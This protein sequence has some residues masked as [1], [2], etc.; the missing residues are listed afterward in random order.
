[1][2]KSIL[3]VCL[4]MSM[5]LVGIPTSAQEPY[6]PEAELG[7]VRLIGTPEFVV[8]LLP[9]GALHY[10]AIRRNSSGFLVGVTPPGWRNDTL[11]PRLVDR[12][13]RATLTAELYNQGGGMYQ[14][15]LYFEGSVVEQGEFAGAG[16]VGSGVI[17]RADNRTAQTIP[18]PNTAPA[19]NLSPVITTFGPFG[20]R[21]NG[22]SARASGSFDGTFY[23]VAPGDN[24][25]RIALRFNTTFAVL[26]S[27][28]NIP[29]PNLIY[30]GQRIRIP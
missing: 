16:P 2:V 27:L 5:L 29:N 9:D 6:D 15:I 26:M 11:S 25:Y 19:S 13:S 7:I 14:A 30:A 4:V 24:L 28:N 8:S 22:A 1:M 3:V 18:F 12:V 17:V 23:T 21:D 20:A 10:Y